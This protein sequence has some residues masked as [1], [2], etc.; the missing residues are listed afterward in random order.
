MEF[1]GYKRRRLLIDKTQYKLLG[2]YLVHFIAVLVIVFSALVIVFT[3]QLEHSSLTAFQRQEVAAKIMWFYGQMWPFMWGIFMLLFIHSVYVTHKI[4]GPLYRI[5]EVLKMVKR[6]N[7]TAKVKLRSG[8]YLRAEEQVVN[9]AIQSIHDK[10]EGLREN[11]SSCTATLVELGR[12]I[13]HGSSD[14]TE[15]RF[16]D[17][18]SQIDGLRNLLGYFK[19]TGGEPDANRGVDREATVEDLSPVA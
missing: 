5:R 11:T 17:L 2:V 10:I 19:V 12:A 3:R 14:Q 13:E 1:R 7:L 18:S 15:Q 4:A 9:E 6:G 16:N 8:D